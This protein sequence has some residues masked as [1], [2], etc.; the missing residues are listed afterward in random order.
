M[1]NELV[2]RTT[3]SHASTIWRV[4]SH[5]TILLCVLFF[6]WPIL[7]SLIWEMSIKPSAIKRSSS[8]SPHLMDFVAVF[9]VYKIII[10]DSKNGIK[11]WVT[12]NWKIVVAHIWPAFTDLTT[13]DSAWGIFRGIHEILRRAGPT[14][15]FQSLT[16]AK[17]PISV[18]YPTFK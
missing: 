13:L 4:R 17:I 12:K 18:P 9:K 2:A 11:N 6:N 8:W 16:F 10:T 1:K 7:L 14:E 15:K 3:L 5:H